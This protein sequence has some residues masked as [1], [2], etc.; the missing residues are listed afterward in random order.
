MSIQIAVFIILIVL[1]V[2]SLL[3]VF[4]SRFN[5]AGG[6]GDRTPT[7]VYVVTGGAMSLL[8]AF[9]MSLTF[10]QYL[11]A[12]QASQQEAGAVMSMSRGATFMPAAV[13]D[14]L[15][16][17][18][19]CSAQNV[20]NIEWPAMSNGNSNPTVEVKKTVDTMD[21]IL[22]TNSNLAGVNGIGIWEEANT[23]RWTAHLQR[24]NVA[25]D[26]V[27]IILWILLIFG[28]L[29]TIG[30]LFVFADPLKPAWAHALVIIGPLFVASAALVVIAF[31]DHPYAN[32][33]GGVTPS[34]MEVTLTNLTHDHIGNIPLPSCPQQG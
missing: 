22:A 13:R 27:P 31:F 34:A 9:T 7:N 11:S 21:G 24:L 8:I 20:I 33:P 23:Q 25:G 32:T 26:G 5:P 2:G 12:Q 1:I 19:V 4:L 29:I 16:D 18:L 15:R 14:P 3:Y 28:S 6:L 30:S 17:Q 10:G